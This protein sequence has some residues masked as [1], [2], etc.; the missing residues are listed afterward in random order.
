MFR[1]S[2][3][4]MKTWRKVGIRPSAPGTV[5]ILLLLCTRYIVILLICLFYYSYVKKEN[6]FRAKTKA[7]VTRNL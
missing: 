2:S 5:F 6:I 4:M 3:E 1:I 7:S